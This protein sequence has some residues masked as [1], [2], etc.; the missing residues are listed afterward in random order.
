MEPVMYFRNSSSRFGAASVGFH[1]LTF[2][3][4][5]GAWGL[6]QLM[7]LIP[8]GDPRATGVAVHIGIG[9]GVL[10][11]VAA[12]LA[13]RMSNPPPPAA[14]SS[15]GGIDTILAEIVHYALYAL[16][17]LVPVF[18]IATWFARGQ[19]LPVFGL[20]HIPTPLDT[21][22]TLARNLIGVHALLAN[23]IVILAALHAAAA[24][25]HHYL[26]G[27]GVLTRMV[28]GLKRRSPRIK[29]AAQV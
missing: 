22:R 26:L 28:P 27:D 5:A 24:L 1:W 8:R 11:L 18:G 3:L 6:G 7:D 10:C 14:H 17:I 12:R 16:L 25:A 29:H 4:V 19:P 9:L 21:D 23:A 20:F 15:F 13:W 2:L